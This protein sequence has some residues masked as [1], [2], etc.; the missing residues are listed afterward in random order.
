MGKNIVQAKIDGVVR[1]TLN[2]P[3]ERNELT[4]EMLLELISLFEELQWEPPESV[5]LLVIRGEG[6][7]FCSGV[8]AAVGEA[9]G[10]DAI[11]K[12]QKEAL[13]F[14]KLLRSLAGLPFPVIAEVKGGASEGGIGIIASC[15]IVLCA[16]G[17]LFGTPEVRNG[18]VPAVASLYVQRK[19]GLSG[20]SLMSLW[21]GGFSAAEAAEFGLVGRI[22]P[23]DEFDPA[24]AAFEEEMSASGPQ[25]MRRMK[26]LL[27]RNF[28]LPV[29]AAEE[30]A[31]LQAAEAMAS[32]EA[33]DKKKK[34][35]P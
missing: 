28:P 10:E 8:E 30:F 1:V 26:K 31:A 18:L 13:L 14:A 23:G 29:R 16:E 4:R 5:K 6:G 25:A 7:F 33:R 9:Q 32:D 35:E 19:T 15:D 12:L 11:D 24:A 21:G 27:L 34:G 20:L 2:R 17:A 3:G 22:L